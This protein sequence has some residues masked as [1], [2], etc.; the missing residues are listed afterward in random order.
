VTT[1]F[2]DALEEAAE[3]RRAP[4]DPAT[5]RA[6]MRAAL[7]PEQLAVLDDPSRFVVL[8]TARA[9]GKTSDLVSDVLEQMSSVENW[10]GCYGALTQ[11]S[12]KEQLWDELRRQDKAFGFGLKFLEHE[13]TVLYPPTGGRLRIRDIANVRAVDKWRGKQYHRVY[14]DECQSMADEVLAYAVAV[15][16]PPTLTRHRG[17]MRIAGTP[18]MRC[19]G[20]WYEVSSR[21]RGCQVTTQPDGSRRA[22]TRPYAERDDPKWAGVSVSWSLHHWPR[23]ANPG[24]PDADR[25]ADEMRRALAATPEAEAALRVEMDGEWPDEDQEPRLYRF[26]EACLWDV[27][28]GPE[29]D[30]PYGLP[31]GHDWLFYLGAD[32]AMKRDAFALELGANALSSP[33]AYHCD[34]YVE[35]RLTI[36]QMAVEINRF[37]RLLGRRLV[38]IVGDS[39]GPKGSEI[40]D[41]LSRVHGIPIEKADKAYKDD[42]IELVSSDIVAGRM[43]IRRGSKLAAQLARLRRPKPNTPASRQPHQEDDAADGWLY[44]R[45]RMIHQFG[46]PAGKQTLDVEEQ[47]AARR[48][49]LFK[50]RK[51]QDPLAAIR[52]LGGLRGL[53]SRIS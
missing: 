30:P 41:E 33:I 51:A 49:E 28:A 19:E 14:L 25:E 13:A 39:Q 32:L 2:L 45:R 26:S 24:L 15:S 40:F 7:A 43:K 31:P 3:D 44:A 22:L 12:G 9:A 42:A 16:L 52:G 48:A 8:R 23:S 6:R 18:R 46:K 10:R 37:R 35:K 27:L 50:P 17:S 5:A 53:R 11:D 47:R 1:P 36:E 38:A 34:E 20:W 4:V 21:K 29:A